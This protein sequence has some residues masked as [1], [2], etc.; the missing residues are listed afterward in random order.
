MPTGLSLNPATGLISGVPLQAGL[1]NFTIRATDA[2]GCIGARPYTLNIIAGAGGAPTLGPL[3]L[4]L[5][6]L[7]LA[8]VGIVATQRVTM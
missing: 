5:L 8:A 4:A 1:F 7:V 2:G 6:A 3:A